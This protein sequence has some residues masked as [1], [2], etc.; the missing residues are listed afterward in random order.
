M[1]TSSNV[2]ADDRE[3]SIFFLQSWIVYSFFFSQPLDPLRW[4]TKSRKRE[5]GMCV[6]NKDTASSVYIYILFICTYK[7]FISELYFWPGVRIE[8]VLVYNAAVCFKKFCFVFLSSFCLFTF[9]ATRFP[10]VLIVCS[11]SISWWFFWCWLIGFPLV[12]F[13]HASTWSHFQSCILPVSYCFFLNLWRFF[14]WLLW[15]LLS[16]L[17]VLSFWF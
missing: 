15:V 13:V 7:T 11:P 2:R 6:N 3:F 9:V 4:K 12:V 8:E 1:H 16:H 17:F 14:F 10:R 5:R